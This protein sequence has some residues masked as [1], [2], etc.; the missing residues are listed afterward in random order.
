[1]PDWNSLTGA[2]GVFRENDVAAVYRATL[3]SSLG[4]A[5]AGVC[6]AS[7]V[8]QSLIGLGIAAGLIAGAL[9]NRLFQASTTRIA[10]N[11]GGR[12]RRRLGSSALLRLGSLTALVL[13]LLV[14]VPSFGAGMLVGLA[15]FQFLLLAY[16]ARLL[17]R[18]RKA[19][20]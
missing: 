5:I 20:P 7:L 9:S 18:Q 10:R 3:V 4:I 12:V 8:G 6:V 19:G 17:V 16:M 13:V 11:P 15:L 1:M 2:G 14:F